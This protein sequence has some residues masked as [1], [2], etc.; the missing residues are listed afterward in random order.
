MNN[1]TPLLDWLIVGGGIHGT[2]VSLYLSRLK[3]VDRDRLRVLDPY[4]QPMARWEANTRN[5]GMAHLRSPHVQSLDN[6]PWSIAT[7]ARTRRGQPLAEFIPTHNRPSLALFRE[8]SH[9]VRERHQLDSLQLQ[10]RATGLT[11]TANGWTVDSTLGPIESRHVVLSLGMSEQPRWPDWAAPLR[12][13]NAPIEHIFTPGFDREALPDWQQAVVIGGGISAAQLALTL[14]VRQPGSVTL[15]IRRPPRVKPFDSDLHWVA[16]TPLTNFRNEPDYAKRRQIIRE[17]RHTGTMPEDVAHLLHEAEAAGALRVCIAE[18][19]AARYDGHDIHLALNTGD[20]LTTD[21][22]ML[23]TGF[24]TQRPGG[25]WL[26]DAI[27]RHNLPT[28]PDGFPIVSPELEWADGLFVT[29][30]L[31]ELQIGPVS[32]NIIGARLGA[33][34]IGRSV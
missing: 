29:G 14:A 30:P 6:D 16:G 13:A 28:A 2:T 24:E 3:G 22:L 10:G 11:R 26:D 7:F 31:A 17:A 4:P 23:A 9:W 27:T 5:V 21:R 15:L 12:D 34:A 19:T 1:S 20:S 33:Q 8:H 18:A 25:A 32:R